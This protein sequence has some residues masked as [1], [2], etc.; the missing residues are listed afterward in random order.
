[1]N[2][3]FLGIEIGA[4]KNQIA[5]GDNKGNILH[6]V[7]EKVIVEEG[8]PGILNWLKKI[9]PVMILKEKEF[10]GK[11]SAI[12]VGFGGI[13]ESSTGKILISVQVKGWQDF[14]LKDWFEEHF[15]LPTTIINDT[16]TGG[17]AEYLCGTGIGSRQF[18]YTNIGSGIGGAFFLNGEYYDGLGYGAAYLGHTYVPDWTSNTPGSEIKVENICSGWAIEKR[19]RTKGYVSDNSYII[20][21]CGGNRA[22]ISCPM[23]AD[24]AK[25]GDEFALS[26]I[27]RVAKSFG[28]G[29]ANVLT[30]ISP[31]CI[32]IGGGVGKM[33]EILLTPIRKYVEERAFISTKGRYKIVECKFSDAAVLVGSILF[34]SKLIIN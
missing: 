23:L 25:R 16:V 34:A 17:Y 30:L 18:F 33:G 29:L 6:S 27:D 7:V 14:M 24:A 2:K 20:E 19:L 9:I 31:D 4:T 12:G 22:E 28:T 1:M 21:L 5:I 13:I 11:V 3:L 26:E 10:G 15:K 32:S 8:A